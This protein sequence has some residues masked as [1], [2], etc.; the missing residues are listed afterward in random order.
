MFGKCDPAEQRERQCGGA[1]DPACRM[2]GA[3]ET[4]RYGL[5][6]GLSDACRQVRKDR[7]RGHHRILRGFRDGRRDLQSG[8]R[9]RELVGVDGGDRG[10]HDGDAQRA[11]DLT[12]RVVDGRCGAGRAFRNGAHQGVRGGP[13]D[14]GDAGRH[15]G[16]GGYDHEPVAAMGVDTRDHEHARR[17]EQQS[18]RDD[19]PVSETFRQ[20][21][22]ERGDRRHDHREGQRRDRRLQ[23]GVSTQCLEPLGGDEDEAEQAEERD[24]DRAGAARERGPSEQADIDERGVRMPLDRRERRK[25]DQG[26]ADAAYDLPGEPAVSRAFDDRPHQQA[27]A[28]HR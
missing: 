19:R 24:A 14:Q 15:Q 6:H 9:V 13:L 1:G 21:R 26:R 8:Q 16:H 28:G 18:R 12:D 3:H 23:C 10:P 5:L 17:Q 2:R 20:L 4:G 22:G 27:H 7:F 25:Y 11:A